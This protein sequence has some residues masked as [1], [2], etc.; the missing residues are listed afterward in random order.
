MYRL[1]AMRPFDRETTPAFEVLVQCTDRPESEVPDARLLSPPDLHS[2]ASAF[3]DI[4]YAQFELYAV[5]RGFF[6]Y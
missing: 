1:E 4:S 2:P 5:P 3:S 6:Q